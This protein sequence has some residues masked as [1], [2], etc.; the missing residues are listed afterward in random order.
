MFGRGV[1]IL[2]LTA[3]A[4]IVAACQQQAWLRSPA[5]EYAQCPSNDAACIQSLEEKGY[6]RAEEPRRVWRRAFGCC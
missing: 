4:L 6:I 5:G 3:A 2:T 1:P